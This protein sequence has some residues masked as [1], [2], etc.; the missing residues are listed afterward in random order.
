MFGPDADHRWMGSIAMDRQ[1]NMA[2]GYNVSSS[3]VFP[4]IR[5]AGRLVSDPLGAMAEKATLQAGSGSET[6]TTEWA[7]YSQTTLDP[8]DDCTFWYSG[9]IQPGTADQNKQYTLST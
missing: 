2:M 4:S 9:T 3:L 1:G 5:I 6:A 8:L 7:D